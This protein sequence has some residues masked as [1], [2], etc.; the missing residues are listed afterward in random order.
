MIY[1][2]SSLTS[3]WPK[4]LLIRITDPDYISDY[5]SGS[6]IIIRT[7]WSMMD[8]TLN[9]IPY[10]YADNSSRDITFS[11]CRTITVWNSVL[12]A[13][14]FVG[15]GL[16]VRTPPRSRHTQEHHQQSLTE[17]K[18]I[19]L[20]C[21]NCFSILFIREVATKVFFLMVV[22]LRHYLPPSSP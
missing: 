12:V 16:S 8:W 9:K 4:C 14:G 18:N 20:V 22:P 2:S 17:H 3:S 1:W 5:R 13:D 21:N 11:Y 7:I 6:G 15:S 10:S 19:T